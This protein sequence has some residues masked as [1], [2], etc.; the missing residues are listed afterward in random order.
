MNKNYKSLEF[1]VVLFSEKDVLNTSNYGD[2]IPGENQL[3]IVGGG[4]FN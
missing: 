3:P 2:F 1:K 4:M